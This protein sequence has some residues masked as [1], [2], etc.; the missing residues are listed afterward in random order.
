MII[1]IHQPEHLPWLGY[2]NKC[3]KADILVHLDNVQFTKNGF[4]NRNRILVRNEPYWVTVPVNT[5]GHTTNKISDILISNGVDWRKKYLGTIKMTYSKYPFFNIYYP[6]LEEVICKEYDKLED[7]NIAIIDFFL[8]ELDIQVKTVRAT[9]LN[10]PFTDASNNLLNIV[11]TLNGKE[12]L[13]GPSGKNYLNLDIFEK[14]NIK[15]SFNEFTHPV[16]KQRSDKFVSHLS[17]LDALF[18]H[19]KDAKKLIL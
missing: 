3:S 7:L 14:N 12:Y 1:T 9:E 17:T 6:V 2:F 8:K 16:Y 18:S 5:K 10:V 15:V 13:S 11:K 4:Q 19:G